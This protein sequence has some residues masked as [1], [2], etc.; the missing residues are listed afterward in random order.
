[1]YEALLKST[2]EYGQDA[3]FQCVFQ[4]SRIKFLHLQNLPLAA[5]YGCNAAQNGSM[6][7][8]SLI[9]QAKKRAEN[10]SRPLFQA[11]Y[12]LI[13]NFSIKAR[14]LSISVFFK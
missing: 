8:A 7:F 14:Y 4:W 2:P 9:L 1:M 13:P 3:A 5:S 10:V 6:S 12:F 11:D